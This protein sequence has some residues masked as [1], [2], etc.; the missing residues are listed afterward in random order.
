[1]ATSAPSSASRSAITRPR[2]RPEPVTNAVLPLSSLVI[3]CLS[4][5][6]KPSARMLAALRRIMS[7]SYPTSAPSSPRS[8]GVR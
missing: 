4:I 7:S 3:A 8:Q 5:A 6:M 2:P 1:M